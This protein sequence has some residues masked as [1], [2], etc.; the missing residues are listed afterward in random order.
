MIIQVHFIPEIEENFKKAWGENLQE[1]I[2]DVAKAFGAGLQS[3]RLQLGSVIRREGTFRADIAFNISVMKDVFLTDVYAYYTVHDLPD[4]LF[5]LLVSQPQKTP[6]DFSPLLR[7]NLSAFQV[8]AVCSN[9]A[10]RLAS[11]FAREGLSAEMKR[12]CA[13]YAIFMRKCRFELVG[14][15]FPC[16]LS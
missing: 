2:R 14:G 1:E 3:L 4:F 12:R 16:E 6:F 5:P 15:W 8:Q 9:A 7:D 10:N 11:D 13:E